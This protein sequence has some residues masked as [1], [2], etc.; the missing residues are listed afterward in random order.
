MTPAHDIAHLL[1]RP[2]L[3]PG[4]RTIVSAVGPSWRLLLVHADDP[5]GISVAEV[6]GDRRRR[7]LRALGRAQEPR[8]SHWVSRVVMDLDAIARHDYAARI[9]HRGASLRQIDLR[10][11]VSAAWTW[12]VR[13][14]ALPTSPPEIM[15]VRAGKRGLEERRWLGTA[16]ISDYDADR[17]CWYAVGDA[18]A[19]VQ[20][21]QAMRMQAEVK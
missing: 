19:L 11:H 4:Y 6:D 13:W 14:Y 9:V 3:P 7:R 18:V 16:A 5:A 2:G 12:V 1:T 21:W 17:W 15:Q 10:A 8:G 20:R